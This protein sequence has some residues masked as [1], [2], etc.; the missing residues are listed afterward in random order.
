[1]KRSIVLLVIGCT[2]LASQSVDGCWRSTSPSAPTEPGPDAIIRGDDGG[3]VGNQTDTSNGTNTAGDA[4]PP[5]RYEYCT[6]AERKA[7]QCKNG[8]CLVTLINKQRTQMTCRCDNGFRGTKCDELQQQADISIVIIII[9]VAIVV[10]LLAIVLGIIAL[11][12]YRQR[13]TEAQPRQQANHQ[14]HNQQQQAVQYTA[15]PTTT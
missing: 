10:L 15:L 9:I 13:A 7:F 8:T 1:M 3:V 12:R 14:Q 2:L 5:T 4:Q 6:R 11:R